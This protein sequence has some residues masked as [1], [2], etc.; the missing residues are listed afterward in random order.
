MRHFSTL[1]GWSVMLHI[2]QLIRN[3]ID[4]SIVS[5]QTTVT[6]I[7]LIVLIIDIKSCIVIEGIDE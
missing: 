3:A 4:T 6:C 7:V 5:F 2:S 1:V